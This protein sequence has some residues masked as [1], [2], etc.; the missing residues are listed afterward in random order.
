MQMLEPNP[1]KRVAAAE[2][3]VHGWV[4]AALPEPPGLHG[5][6]ATAGAAAASFQPVSLAAHESLCE[7][8][9]A[10]VRLA[11]AVGRG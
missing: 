2:C 5:K 6:T 9:R 3:S 8:H 11:R 10:R 1:G 7:D 4:R